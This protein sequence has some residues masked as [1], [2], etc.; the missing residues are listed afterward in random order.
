MKVKAGAIG[1]GQVGNRQEGNSALFPIP[2]WLLAIHFATTENFIY[3]FFL[4]EKVRR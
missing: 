1:N 3:P 4:L 2:Y